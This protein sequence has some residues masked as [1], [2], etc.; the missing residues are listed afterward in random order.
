MWYFLILCVAVGTGLM[1]PKIWKEITAHESSH[2]PAKPVSG[3]KGVASKEG[4]A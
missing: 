3:Y 4:S 2:A 1:G